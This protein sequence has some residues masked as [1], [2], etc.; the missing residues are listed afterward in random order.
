MTAF[1]ISDDRPG[2]GG[3]PGPILAEEV[4]GRGGVPVVSFS[5]ADRTRE[6]VIERLREYHSAGVRDLLLVTGDYEPA[7]AE[8]GYDPSFDLDSIQLLMFL[9]EAAGGDAAFFGD[10]SKGTV[11]SPFKGLEA[12]V[13]W[14]Y[15]RLVRKGEAGG[16]FVV[17]QAGYDP[18]VWDEL[19]RFSRMKKL[20]G[21]VM[22]NL[23][24]PDP[25]TALRI[26]MGLVP[27]ISLPASLAKQIAKEAETGL[28]VAEESVRR[29][30]KMAA[31]L[32][33]L[34][35]QG[36]LLGAGLQYE[37]VHL[38]LEESEK[39]AP[40][41]RECLE[42]IS[43]PDPRFYYFRRGTGPE[44]NEDVPEKVSPRKRKH[45]M[46]QL[47]YFVDYVAFGSWPPF[48]HVL[49]AVCRFCDTRPFW[50]RVLWFTELVSKGPMYG[51]RMCGDCTLYA[52][53]FFCCEAGCP[54][55]MVNGPCGGSVEG[56]C[57]VYPGKKRCFWVKVYDRLKGTVERP[58][59]VAPPIPAKDHSL[60]GTCSWIS[61]CLGR[62]HRKIGTEKK[63]P[64]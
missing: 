34:G 48:F 51:C 20:S 18:R 43:F 26:A 32:R 9:R 14:Q 37:E 54:K 57:E 64:A 63:D 19:V 40:R 36:V 2:A 16:E 62:D 46:Y 17:S 24:L 4:L 12:E 28:G 50:K 22:G 49:T 3:I 60:D 8:K 53:G 52:T 30:G 38:L 45:P 11:V 42:E 61:F 31:V 56:F 55:K 7:W 33:G 1:F 6:E 10:F 15:A 58:G 29:G 27:G 47:S 44:L 23:L 13:M 35:Y 5:P 41:W 39:H 21:P 25:E 59:F